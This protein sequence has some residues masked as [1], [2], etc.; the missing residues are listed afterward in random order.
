M[1]LASQPRHSIARRRPEDAPDREARPGV[2]ALLGR[3]FPPCRRLGDAYWQ[4][5]NLNE[6]IRVFQL[7]APVF[8]RYSL[9]YQNVQSSTGS[10]LI[11]L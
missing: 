4:V 9:V 6:A 3:A 11:E 2:P 10:M 7:N 1:L 5:E 8:F